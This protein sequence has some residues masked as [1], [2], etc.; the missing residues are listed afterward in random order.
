MTSVPHVLIQDRG[1][2]YMYHWMIYMLGGLRRIHPSEPGIPTKIHFPLFQDQGYHSQSL[3]L[4]KDVF[5]V[6]TPEPDTPTISHDGEPIVAP[7]QVDP[8]TYDYLRQLFLSRVPEAAVDPTKKYY[9]T[10]KNSESVSPANAGRKIRQILNE[11]EFI[12]ALKNM[13][14]QIIHFEDY[15]F[16]EKIRIFQTASVIVSPNSA[17]LTFSLFA[18][19]QTKIIEILPA[20]I[21]DHD[22]YKNICERLGI[23]YSRFTN[24]T[25][26]GDAPALG[27][28]WNMNV[29]TD[30]LIEYLTSDTVPNG[31]VTFL[32]YTHSDY[33]DLWPIMAEKLSLLP[34][35]IKKCI[36]VNASAPTESLSEHFDSVCTYDDTETYPRKLTSILDS[37][38]TDYVVLIHDND[39][40]VSFDRSDFNRLLAL[41][42]QRA[43]DRCMFGV[44]GKENP[45]VVTDNFSIGRINGMS[46][47]HFITPY[48]VGPSVWNVGSFKRALSTALDISYRD[49][50][51]SQ[52]QEYCKS[53]LNMYAFFSHPGRKTFYCIGRPFSESFQFLHICAQGKLLEDPLYM[54]Q[55]YEL[56]RIKM[57]H[58]EILNRGVLLNQ[59]HIDPGFRTV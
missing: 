47:P 21:E 6:C 3:N 24:L 20:V 42:Q 34:V 15:T 19:P 29:H 50:E 9:I 48:D 17:C 54:D 12:P 40:I 35:N 25:T 56:M 33:K 10:R 26:A 43:I 36:G 55:Q 2:V 37:I 49:I 58:P 14:F 4:I 7:D 57:M 41:I 52:I 53:H 39:L 13:G 28:V 44:V 31:N 5:E 16:E 11:N 23:P 1:H 59:T 45:T 32:F 38:H 22:H 8:A 51:R 46:T 27:S 30:A 18:S